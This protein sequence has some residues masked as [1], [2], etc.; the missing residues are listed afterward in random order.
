M[1][2]DKVCD[3]VISGGRLFDLLA[4]TTGIVWSPVARSTTCLYAVRPNASEL[5]NTQMKCSVITTKS[6]RY[7]MIDSTVGLSGHETGRWEDLWNKRSTV[8][9]QWWMVELWWIGLAKDL[10]RRWRK[11]RSYVNVYLR[12]KRLKDEVKDNDV[13]IQGGA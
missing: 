6:G 1:Y 8:H 11:R 4:P 7:K 2:V 10:S 5:T 9:L 13:D 3:D 12:I